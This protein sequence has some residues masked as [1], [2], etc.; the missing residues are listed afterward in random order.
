MPPHT[1]LAGPRLPTEAE[2]EYAARGGRRGQLPVGRRAR[3]GRRA[4]D[5]R[6]AGQFPGH[7]TAPTV[8]G[9]APV[10]AFA[11]NG[12]GLYNMTGNV[13]EW[14][15]DWFDPAYCRHSERRNPPGR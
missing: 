5:E 15:A 11:P 7:N 9:T 12:Y 13:W 8:P 3:P 1:A 14:C 10:D 2:W 4:P 6:L